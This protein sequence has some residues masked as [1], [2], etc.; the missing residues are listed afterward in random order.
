DRLR[1]RFTIR[2]VDRLG[3]VV[4]GSHDLYVLSGELR[5]LLL[6]VQVAERFAWLKQHILTTPLYAGLSTRLRVESTHLLEHRFV[7]PSFGTCLVHNL[8]VEGRVLRRPETRGQQQTCTDT[9]Y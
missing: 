2:D 7:P 6:I 1:R 3:R 8:A 9:H 5:G 4:Q